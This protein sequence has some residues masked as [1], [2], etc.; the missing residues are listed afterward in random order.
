MPSINFTLYS[1]HRPF[2]SLPETRHSSR[3]QSRASTIQNCWL[4]WAEQTSDLL[5]QQTLKDHL[6]N[7]FWPDYQI[8]TNTLATWDVCLPISSSS[9]SLRQ[10]AESETIIAYHVF[11]VTFLFFIYSKELG[12]EHL[13]SHTIEKEWHS[14][15]FGFF[16]FLSA[17]HKVA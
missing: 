16:G 6:K 11:F 4:P 3:G 9:F 17:P 13:E 12:A 15:K 1:F 7:S 10:D 2:L 8:E 14:W 5:D